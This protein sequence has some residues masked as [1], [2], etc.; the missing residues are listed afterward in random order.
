MLA[1]LSAAALSGSSINCP[2]TSGSGFASAGSTD[3]TPN[4]VANATFTCTLPA[5]PVGDVVTSVQVLIQNDYS[6]GSNASNNE[7]AYTYQLGGLGFTTALT[8]YVLGNFPNDLSPTSGGIIGQSG[9]P[10][11]VNDSAEQ[12]EC[13]SSGDLFAAGSTFTVTGLSSWVEGSV[14]ANGSVDI[15]VAFNYTVG[16]GTATPEP[17]TMALLGGAGLIGVGLAARRRRKP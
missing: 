14:G 11:C 4:P 10:S 7:V 2:A 9:V 15:N 1:A 6:L 16:A 17:A 13:D 3:S 8:T 12:N 5:V